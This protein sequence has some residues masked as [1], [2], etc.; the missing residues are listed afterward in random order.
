MQK[1]IGLPTPAAW[2][3]KK[4]VDATLP[5]GLLPALCAI[6][7][8][9]TSAVVTKLLLYIQRQFYV[10]DVEYVRRRIHITLGDGASET[11]LWPTC[12][13]MKLHRYR[14]RRI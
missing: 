9:N 14:R 5:H 3:A 4:A 8:V 7:W 1:S 13:F 10:P 6:K 11:V 12:Y 2:S